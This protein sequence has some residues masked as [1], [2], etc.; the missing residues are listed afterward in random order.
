MTKVS[1]PFVGIAGVHF[2][3]SE[4]SRRGMIALP[5]TRNTAAYDVVVVTPDGTKHANIQVKASLKRRTF[6]L[7]PPGAK[8][9]TGAHDYYVLLHWIERDQRFEGFMLTGKQARSEVKRGENFQRKRMHLGARKVLVPSIYV[10]AKV[11]ARADRWREK[12]LTWGL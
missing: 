5:T 1:K 4:L 12:W 10:G 9:K 6:F 11:K 7:M 3:V 2:V 8:V